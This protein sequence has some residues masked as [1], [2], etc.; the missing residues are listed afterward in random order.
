[1][2]CVLQ[3]TSEKALRKQLQQHFKTDMNERKAF[4]KEH[5]SLSRTDTKASESLLSAPLACQPGGMQEP[6]CAAQHGTAKHTGSN[7]ST[8]HVTF[9]LGAGALADRTAGSTTEQPSHKTLPLLAC[10]ATAEACVAHT[11]PAHS[12]VSCPCLTVPCCDAL[13]HVC[14]AMLCWSPL[15]VNYFIQH[16]DKKD[17]LEP[18]GFE[19]QSALSQQQQREQQKAAAA[20]RAALAAPPAK[21]SG[22]VIVVGAGP[23]GLAAATQL[24]VRH[25]RRCSACMGTMGVKQQGPTKGTTAVVST[26]HAHRVSPPHSLACVQQPAAKFH[27]TAGPAQVALFCTAV[28][29]ASSQRMVPAYAP[30]SFY[31]STAPPLGC[32]AILSNH[33]FHSTSHSTP[34]HLTCLLARSPPTTTAKTPDQSPPLT[35]PSPAPHQPHPP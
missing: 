9:V 25:R 2:L 22:R 19:G 34:S 7:D 31:L 16:L 1:V 26:D 13:C 15:Q 6:G 28:Q 3:T 10:A 12:S 5:V 17:T 18:L 24:Q 29:Q 35:C 4:I 32:S 11:C 27:S 8:L 21:P 33:P 14:A 20:A 30:A 23:A